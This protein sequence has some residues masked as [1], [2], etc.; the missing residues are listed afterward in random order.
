MLIIDPMH[1]LFLGS[2]KY[3]T[4]N[5]LINTPILDNSK[6]KIIQERLNSIIVS[7]DI[8]RSPRNIASRSTFTA[9]QWINW[10]L[11]LSIFCLH[12]LMPPTHIECWHSFVL[13][14]RRLC[15]KSLT[16]NIIVADLLL[17][18]FSKFVRALF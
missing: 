1:N 7:F 17:M 3:Y 14:C 12:G 15:K 2:A 18:K 6:F 10:T 16:D 5:I 9:H 11:Y 4:Q 8:G 13:G